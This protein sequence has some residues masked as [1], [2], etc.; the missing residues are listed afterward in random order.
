[1]KKTN[2]SEEELKKIK[3]ELKEELKAEM[4]KEA[5]EEVKKEL[6]SEEPI[7]KT[8]KV[9]SNASY[10][11]EEVKSGEFKIPSRKKTFFEPTVVE[12]KKEEEVI[13]NDEKASPI[14][15]VTI[16]VLLVVGILVVPKIYN[17]Y[18]RKVKQDKIEDPKVEETVKEKIT[19]KWEDEAIKDIYIPVMRKNKHQVESYYQLDKISLSDLS[20]TELL[21]NTLK[22]IYSGHIADYTGAYNGY[23]CTNGLNK[24][25]KSSYVDAHISQTITKINYHHE[26]FVVPTYIDSQYA[27][28]WKYDANQAIYVYYGD[29]NPDPTSDITY[30]DILV[31]DKINT[32]EDGNEVELIYYIGFVKVVGNTYTIYSDANYTDELTSGTLVSQDVYNELYT[33]MKGMEDYLSEYKYTYSRENCLYKNFCFISGEYNE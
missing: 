17:K 7:K 28:L 16:L 4:L 32:S 5:K 6:K 23:A 2:L 25:I 21:Y 14:L 31:E 1:M 9:V 12:K 18:G 22:D 13:D 20:N 19:Y 8:K 33:I 29:C 26:D 10:K 27:G 3:E 15:I 30:Y 11:P 24:S